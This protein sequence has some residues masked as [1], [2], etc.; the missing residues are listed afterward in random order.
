VTWVEARNTAAD[1]A[2]SIHDDAA[3]R[4]LGFSGG[5]VPGNVHVVLVVRDLVERYGR[6]WYDRGFLRHTWIKPVYAG[7][8]VQVVMEDT[9]PDE[10]AFRMEKRDG[11]LVTAGI[12][13]LGDVAPWER[14]DAPAL[15]PV[16]DYDPLPDEAPGQEFP[17]SPLEVDAAGV[18]R[19]LAGY[20]PNPWYTDSSPWG[21]PV[22]PTV[23]Q[24]VLA[25]AYGSR[26][27][28]RPAL[29]EMRA[30]MNATS[31]IIHRAPLF[32]GRKYER[33]SRIVEKGTKGRHAFRTMEFD[34]LDGPPGAPRLA[35]RVRWKIKWVTARPLAATAGAG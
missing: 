26:E 35:A 29:L 7:E 3:A 16:G 32:V 9:A 24:L 11:I 33:R 30:G 4:R 23:S 22:L 13:G 5:L 25:G 8:E 34:V 20:D 19:M 21:E 10:V 6:A 12:A 14:P 2:Q 1:V 15:Q 17:A 27:T 31:E 18:E 28:P